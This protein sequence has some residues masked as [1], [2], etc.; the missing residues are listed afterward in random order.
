MSAQPPVPPMKLGFWHPASLVATWFG[1]G[2]L[3]KAP[4]TFGSLSALI[5]AWVIETVA[6]PPGLGIALVLLF[7]LGVWAAGVYARATGQ[8]DPPAVVVDEVIGQWLVVLVMPPDLIIYAAGFALFRV[9]DIF[10][11]WPANWVERRVKGGLG[12]VLDDIVAAVYAGALLFVLS[13]LLTGG[14]YF[15]NPN[16]TQ[17]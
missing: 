11:I 2:L 9:A 15:I 6:G 8:S 17:P 14:F 5:Y 16:A 3:P 1:V 13:G 12:I 4:G 7:P 10:K